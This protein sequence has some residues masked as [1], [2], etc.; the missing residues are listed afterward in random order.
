MSAAQKQKEP[1]KK[2]KDVEMRKQLIAEAV[3]SLVRDG[4]F[5]CAW[6]YAKTCVN[7]CIDMCMREHR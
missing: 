3:G 1:S 5:G 7:T 2:V 4:Y 6:T